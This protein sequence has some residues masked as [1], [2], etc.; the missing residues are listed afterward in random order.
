MV[1]GLNLNWQGIKRK[2]VYTEGAGL[3]CKC[4]EQ[5]TLEGSVQAG[6]AKFFQLVFKIDSS[7]TTKSHM[8]SM[9]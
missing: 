1:A 7:E 6:G 5:C 3:V 2:A 8:F 4:T 9:S